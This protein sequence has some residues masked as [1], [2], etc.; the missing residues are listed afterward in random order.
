[1][2][3]MKFWSLLTL[4]TCLLATPVLLSCGGDDD[5]DNN[6]G[7]NSQQPTSNSIV[8]TWEWVDGDVD[9]S[10]NKPS[11]VLRE[12]G[13][14]EARDIINY[15]GK[16]YWGIDF[17]WK[18]EGNILKK[19]IT[20]TMKQYT[21]GNYTTVAMVSSTEA[22][23]PGD[24]TVTFLDGDRMRWEYTLLGTNHYYILHRVSSR[25]TQTAT[26]KSQLTDLIP[27]EF[28]QKIVKHV[29]IYQGN[30]AT[31]LEGTYLFSPEVVVDE[32]NNYTAGQAMAPE[33]IRLSNQNNSAGTITVEE[34]YRSGETSKSVKALVFGTGNDFTVFYLNEG[35][36]S[37]ATFQTGTI[38]SGTWTSS[39]IS[40]LKQAI[41]MIKKN[42]PDKKIIP[43]GILRVFKELYE[44]S[45]PASWD[46]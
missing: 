3:T 4:L 12:D 39:G 21:D 24:D 35:S 14:G 20:G 16:T 10:A 40:N 22:G 8:G 29:N 43:V 30:T 44:L 5:D 28:L 36:Q 37:G 15:G 2:K 26:Y 31:N 46:E 32:T 45:A 17:T 33:R 11:F 34:K 18:L 13:T 41:V 25:T 19:Y 7:G 6:G 27:E 38:I 9:M 42:D 23:D 1:M